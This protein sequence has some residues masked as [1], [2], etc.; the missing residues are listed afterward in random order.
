LIPPAPK[1]TDR[2]VAD[3]VVPA[4]PDPVEPAAAAP[5]DPA[6]LDID[7]ISRAWPLILEKVKR[8]KI[9]SHAMLLPATPVGWKHGELVL[10]FE[11]RSRFHRDKISEPAQHGPLLDAFHEVLGVRPTLMCVLGSEAPPVTEAPVSDGMGPSREELV[12]EGS[13]DP[14]PDAI[15]MIRRAFNASVVTEDK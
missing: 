12:D 7:R 8:R 4:A 10:E 13:G 5:A 1:D 2:R 14:P 6:S 11:P 15:E 9:S 3:A